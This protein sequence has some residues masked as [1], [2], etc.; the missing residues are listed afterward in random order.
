MLTKRGWYLKRTRDDHR[1]FA[2]DNTPGIVTVS[3]KE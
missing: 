2:N 3:G 1:Q